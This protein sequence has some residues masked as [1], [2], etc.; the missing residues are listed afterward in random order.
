MFSNIG[1]ALKGFSGLIENWSNK[2]HAWRFFWNF[3]PIFN[4]YKSIIRFNHYIINSGLFLQ[5]INFP[6]GLKLESKYVLTICKMF[7]LLNYCYSFIVIQNCHWLICIF[8][9]TGWDTKHPFFV[10]IRP[11]VK[12]WKCLSI[13]IT[14]IA[15]PYC[16]WR[17]PK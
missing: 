17:R 11:L 1:T 9:Y 4:L 6:W 12:I 3:L 13:F 16:L 2:S 5:L 15:Q 8:I 7:F 10:A 14:V